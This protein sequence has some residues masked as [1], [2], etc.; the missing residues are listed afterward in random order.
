MN[1]YIKFGENL[2]IC[3]QDIEWKQYYDRQTEEQTEWQTTQ[4]LYSPPFSTRGYYNTFVVYKSKKQLVLKDPAPW[5][6]EED[7]DWI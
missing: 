5:G 3:S 6:E 7:D 1:A 4:I 2:S